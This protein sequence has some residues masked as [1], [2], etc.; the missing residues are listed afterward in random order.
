MCVYTI[1]TQSY[2]LPVGKECCGCCG[3]VSV[4]TVAVLAGGG[5]V[6]A[7]TAWTGCKCNINYFQR[8][9]CKITAGG[10]GGD[11]H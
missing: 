9:L 7:T 10:R 1:I 3:V 6:L 5:R 8:H 4:E 2:V 11:T